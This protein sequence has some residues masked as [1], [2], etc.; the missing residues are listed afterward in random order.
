MLHITAKRIIK[1]IQSS[2]LV[3]SYFTKSYSIPNM[4]FLSCLR[5]K[6]SVLSCADNITTDPIT[7]S[8][9]MIRM[10]AID[11]QDWQKSK[12][13]Y[14]GTVYHE[15]CC[16]ETYYEIKRSIQ[17]TDVL[18]SVTVYGGLG[19]NSAFANCGTKNGST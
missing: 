5:K 6:K 13:P 19:R 8:P 3:S 18:C 11:V 15:S 14:G 9:Q 10:I 17:L 12:L 2:T 16:R 1:P 7:A 4:G